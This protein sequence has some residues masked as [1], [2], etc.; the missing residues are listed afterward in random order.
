MHVRKID[1]LHHDLTSGGD[2]LILEKADLGKSISFVTDRLSG[3][4]FN[5]E[6]RMSIWTTLG[7]ITLLNSFLSSGEDLAGLMNTMNR[8]TF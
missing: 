4:I 2:K 3:K 6:F 7:L 8:I 5:E 1:H